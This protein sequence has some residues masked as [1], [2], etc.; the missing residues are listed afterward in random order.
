MLHSAVV[1]LLAQL[2]LIL[3]DQLSDQA[4][5][6]LFLLELTGEFI[7]PHELIAHLVLHLVDALGN[8]FHLFV[9]TRL[10]VAYLVQVGCPGLH[11]NL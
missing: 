8:S 7:D 6:D 9:D 1:D 3:L 10:Q 2:G 4:Q 5:S 11:L